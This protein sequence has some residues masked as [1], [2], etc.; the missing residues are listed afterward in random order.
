MVIAFKITKVNVKNRFA[1]P[2]NNKAAT[3]GPSR[4]G[5]QLKYERF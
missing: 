1:I 2:R 3:G 5:T 4:A